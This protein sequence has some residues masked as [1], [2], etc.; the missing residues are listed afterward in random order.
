MSGASISTAQLKRLQTLYSQLAAASADPA[1]KTRAGRLEFVSIIAN[2][3]VASFNDLTRDEAIKCIDRIQRS[4]VTTQ[5]TGG[6]KRMSRDRAR[7]H[8]VDGRRDGGEFQHQPQLAQ[9]LDL[10]TI[11]RYYSRLGW[12]R[13]RFDAWLRSPRTPLGRGRQS[14]PQIRTVA[15]AN[16]VRWALK[17]MLQQ[18]GLWMEKR[19]A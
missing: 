6:V 2:R 12:D 3:R 4:S 10:E 9:S 1:S 13:D 18:Q 16:R 8:G 11:E 15:D 14:N 7:R 5:M 19:S 17:R